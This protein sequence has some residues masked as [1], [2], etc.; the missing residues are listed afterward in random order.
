MLK[1]GTRANANGMAPSRQLNKK[2]GQRCV[3]L[4]SLGQCVRPFSAGLV[5]WRL[6]RGVLIQLYLLLF[7][8]PNMFSAVRVVLSFIALLR[9][10]AP[11]SPTRLSVF[12]DYFMQ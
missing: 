10:C 3:T 5:F 9:A 11:S 4:Q 7:N 12:V 1:K 2:F 6:W 8:I